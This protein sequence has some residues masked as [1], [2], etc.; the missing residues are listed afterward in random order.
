M[1]ASEARGGERSEQRLRVLRSRIR[2]LL[3]KKTRWTFVEEGSNSVEPFRPLTGCRIAA[4][5]LD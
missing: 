4:N 5:Y 3:P 2:R 1:K